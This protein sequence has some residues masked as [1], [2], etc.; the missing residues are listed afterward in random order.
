MKRSVKYGICGAVLAGIIGG[1]AVL[2]AGSASGATVTLVVDG[3][4][5]KMTTSAADVATVL[6]SAGYTVGPHD[7]VAPS[8]S[9]KVHNGDKIVYN[10]GRLL[11]LTVNGHHKSVWT[12]APTVS[13]ALAQLGYPVADLVSVSRS[14]RLP[15]SV[16]VLA[17]RTP[18]RIQIIADGKHRA[19]ETT[20][21]NVGGLLAS[22]RITVG[23][24]DVL[25]QARTAKLRSGEKLVLKRGTFRTEVVRESIA[26][27]VQ[28]VSDSS[29][30]T[31]QSSVVTAGVPGAANV[32]YRVKYLDGVRTSDRTQV[33][34]TTVLAPKAE[35]EKVGTK[36]RPAPAAP[37]ASNNGLNWDG[38]AACE[39][40]GNWAINTGNGYYGGLQFSY[41]TW[42]SYGGGAYAQRADLASREQQIA[43]ATNVYN[44]VGSS[45]WPVCGAYL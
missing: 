4:A 17:L 8:T 31:D 34:S 38:V 27:P 32:T 9:A 40:G 25:N 33:A 42:L 3:Q 18:V 29:M 13:E 36:Q 1:T 44:S 28:H 15:L 45:A 26:Y 11:H 12:T 20:E 35:V 24:D 5:K 16:T 19:V 37:P 10:R 7:I 22:L 23:H 6:K 14:E 43:I 30:Y 21:R 41:S 2:A 39:S